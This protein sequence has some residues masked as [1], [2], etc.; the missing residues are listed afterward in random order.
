[1]EVGYFTM[2]LHPPG[3][4]LTQTLDDDLEQIITLDRLGY[5]EAWIGEHFTAQWENIPAPDLLIAMALGLTENIVL[6]TG[7]TCMPNHNPFMVAHRIAQLDH[8]AHGRFRWGVGS[9]GFPGD[10]TVFGFDAKSGEHRTMT[11]D[12]LDLVLKLWDDPTPGVYEHKFWRFTVPEPIEEYGLA[13]HLKPYQKPHPP[14]GVA[15][16]SPKSD[17]LVLAG[18]RGYIPMSINIVP[19]STLVTHW[20]SVQQGASVAGRTPDRS[21]WRIAREV[22]VADT[23]EE[24]R[25]EALEGVLARD[26]EN[27]FLRLLPHS[28]MM[29]LIKTDPDM[30]DSDVTPEYL[31]D[32]IWLVGTPDDVAAKIRD[33][34]AE[35]GGFGVLLAM[36]HEWQPKEKWL[37]SMSLL[38]DEVMPKVADL[39]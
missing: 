6:G 33:I 9:G 14:I 7:V 20:E 26:F 27:Y 2:P 30:P 24:A 32:N 5:S 31:V 15:G 8:M 1:M 10:F 3:S 21:Q 22:Y 28:R 37:R 12:A 36:G 39:S 13:F 16:V 38:V 4:N 17:T 18:E 23:A 35:V 29:D 19:V 11:R 34:H 25:K